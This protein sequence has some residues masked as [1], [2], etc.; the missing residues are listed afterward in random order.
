MCGAPAIVAYLE[1]GL[2]EAPGHG[3]HGGRQRAGDADGGQEFG[4]VGGEAERDGAV[5]I[6]VSGCVV[7]I[8][9]KVGHIQFASVLNTR[10]RQSQNSPSTMQ[11]LKER[12][13]LVTPNYLSDL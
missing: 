6:Q 8:K 11:T 12:L 4:N 2:G 3:D 5:G 13:C 7:Y 1:V 9:P 10:R